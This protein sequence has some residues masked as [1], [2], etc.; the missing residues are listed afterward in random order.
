MYIVSKWLYII[1]YMFYRQLL[2]IAFDLR[3]DTH[4]QN[5]IKE[6]FSKASPIGKD[7]IR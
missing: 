4:T 6:M 3:Q 7:L 5:D 2:L 1:F